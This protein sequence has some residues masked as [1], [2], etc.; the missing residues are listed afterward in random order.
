MTI[1][2]LK[3]KIDFV[4]FYVAVF[5]CEKGTQC[6]IAQCC[7]IGKQFFIYVKKVSMRIIGSR[8]WYNTTAIIIGI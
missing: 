8:C 1:K 5:V 2:Q 7:Q 6:N 3:V 4:L